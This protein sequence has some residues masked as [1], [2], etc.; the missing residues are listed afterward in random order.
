MNVGFSVFAFGHV[1]SVSLASISLLLINMYAYLKKLINND[2]SHE[3][4]PKIDG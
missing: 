4:S 3:N 2:F 1:V